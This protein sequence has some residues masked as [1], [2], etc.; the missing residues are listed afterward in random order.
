MITF[1]LLGML[2]LTW[3]YIVFVLWPAVHNAERSRIIAEAFKQ[4][5]Y[6]NSFKNVGEA[7]EYIDSR[8]KDEDAD[9]S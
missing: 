1:I 6:D 4:M 9:P 5:K 7:Q 2:F 8:P 3:I